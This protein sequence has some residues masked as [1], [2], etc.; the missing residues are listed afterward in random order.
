MGII[1]K[2]AVLPLYPVLRH[3][4]HPLGLVSFEPFNRFLSNPTTYNS[5]SDGLYSSHHSL[6]KRLTNRWAMTRFTQEP[7]RKGGTPI[8][9]S[10][11]M[12]EEA[13]L[14]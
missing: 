14:A 2:I 3:F 8:S 6:H 4:R 9:K 11:V 1:S 10:L 12:V 13:S 5:W 7:T